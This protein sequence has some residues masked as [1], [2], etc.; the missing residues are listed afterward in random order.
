MNMMRQIHDWRE[1]L[2]DRRALLKL[3][4]NEAMPSGWSVEQDEELFKVVDEHGL[5]NIAANI[6]NRTA[7]Q[8]VIILF[9]CTSI[10]DNGNFPLLLIFMEKKFPNFTLF[11]IFIKFFIF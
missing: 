1:S 3:C 7:F 6:L 2:T 5:D 9:F 10:F 8:K 4:S 11:L